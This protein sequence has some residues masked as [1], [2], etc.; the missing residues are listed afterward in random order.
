MECHKCRIELTIDNVYRCYDC[1]IAYCKDCLKKHCEESKRLDR[2]VR[3]ID[4]D[5][6]LGKEVLTRL[7]D[8]LQERFKGQI[9][10]PTLCGIA[11][12]R[13]SEAHDMIK[14]HNENAWYTAYYE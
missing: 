3:D 13:L 1:D 6:S 9:G 5:F 10:P 2:L 11:L 4:N 14:R 7:Q 8:K 12:E